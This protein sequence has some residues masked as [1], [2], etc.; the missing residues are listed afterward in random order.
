MAWLRK[1]GES[2]LLFPMNMIDQIKILKENPTYRVGDIFLER[3]QNRFEQ[4]RDAILNDPQYKDTILYDYLIKKKCP[5]DWGTLTEVI[6]DHTKRFSYTIPE[7]NSLVVH[8]R[9]GDIW[10]S[11]IPRNQAKRATKSLD[12]YQDFYCAAPIKEYEIKK[13]YL[14]TAL[15]FGADDTINQYFYNEEAVSKSLSLAQNFLNQCHSIN[16]PV[17]IFSNYST[18]KDLC[19]MAHAKY[20]VAGISKFSSE[21]LKKCNVYHYQNARHF[22]WGVN[23]WKNINLEQVRYKVK[24]K[25]EIKDYKER[26]RKEKEAKRKEKEA[27]KNRKK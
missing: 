17:E 23:Q 24:R 25:K 20:F 1:R 19:F 27:W 6:M 12:Q 15:H 21:I 9:L 13:V 7:E 4:D 5:K 14:V 26:K 16:L 10:G 3:G 18:D 2:G 22:H 11:N 8:M